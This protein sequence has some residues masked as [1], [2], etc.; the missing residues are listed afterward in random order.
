MKAITLKVNKRAWE[1]IKAIQS[2][3]NMIDVNVHISRAILDTFK[4]RNLGISKFFAAKEGKLQEWQ[5]SK[6]F[7]SKLM[8]EHQKKVRAYLLTFAP[9]S[10][11][12]CKMYK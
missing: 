1:S 4:L 9:M 11:R 3:T 2:C 6:D 5:Q 7:N 12:N 10:V 8:I